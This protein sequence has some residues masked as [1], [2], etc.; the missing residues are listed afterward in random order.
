FAVYVVF[1]GVFAFIFIFCW[2]IALVFLCVV[3]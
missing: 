1:F 3:A 2:L